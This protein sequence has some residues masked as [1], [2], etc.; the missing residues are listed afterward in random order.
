[1]SSPILD[2]R[3]PDREPTDHE[4]ADHESANHESADLASARE[5]LA[6]LEEYAASR[7]AANLLTSSS[8]PP[9]ATTTATPT[10]TPATSAPIAEPAPASSTPVAAPTPAVAAT[11]AYPDWS[12]DVLPS[13]VR[14]ARF[15]P[16]TVDLFPYD[17][18]ASIVG[19]AATILAY[20]SLGL[21]I[22]VVITAAL[23]AGGEGARRRRWFPSLGLNLVIGTIVGLLFV[24][25]A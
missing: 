23:V 15:D 14:R 13:R 22:A 19:C 2:S 8:A 5:I 4:P 24:F 9:A 12:L 25:T 1:V 7:R 18:A 6:R 20:V 11:I 10:P 3:Q 16:A 21:P 17:L